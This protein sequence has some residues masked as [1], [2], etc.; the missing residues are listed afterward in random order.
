MTMQEKAGVKVDKEIILAYTDK[1][2]GFCLRRLGS[3]DAAEEL[4]QDIFAELLSGFGKYEINHL[5][6]WIWRVARNRYAR[7]I[8]AERREL[9]VFQNI[10]SLECFEAEPEKQEEGDSDALEAASL[11]VRS[12]AGQISGD[13]DRLLYPRAHLC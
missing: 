7:Y 8:A 13:F 4:A 10:D 3:P 6:A 9:A 2:F 1:I 11:A 12:L 5:N